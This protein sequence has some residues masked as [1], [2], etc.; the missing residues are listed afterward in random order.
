M[1]PFTG[2]I[3][4]SQVQTG[5]GGFTF[6]V[7]TLDSLSSDSPIAVDVF[8]HQSRKICPFF[9]KLQRTRKSRSGLPVPACYCLSNSLYKGHLGKLSA[10][11]RAVDPGKT[12]TIRVRLVFDNPDRLLSGRYELPGKGT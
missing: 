12:G 7:T 8:H 3:S 2:T 9:E 1:R 11:D 4:I 10:I 6:G 5:R